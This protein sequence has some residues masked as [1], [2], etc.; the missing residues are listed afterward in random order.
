V[1]E[2]EFRTVSEKKLHRRRFAIV[3]S[4]ASILV[5]FVFQVQSEASQAE[6]K[7]RAFLDKIGQAFKRYVNSP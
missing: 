3:K 5:I 1:F 2:F 7:R 6:Q 4:V